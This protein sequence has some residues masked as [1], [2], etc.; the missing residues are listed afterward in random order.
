MSG[1]ETLASKRQHRLH[2][3]GSGAD[4]LYEAEMLPVQLIVVY[5]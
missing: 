3:L 4:N 5:L 2:Y 1:H